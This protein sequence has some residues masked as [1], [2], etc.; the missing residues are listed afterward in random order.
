MTRTSSP[1]WV[2]AASKL[3]QPGLIARLVRSS[4]RAGW[5]RGVVEG[6]PAWTVAGGLA[7]LAYMAGRAWTKETD[8]IF[9]EQL[10]PGQVIR[11]AHDAAPLP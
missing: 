9:S 7:L 2:D 6:S 8:V 5:Q 4:M 11:I 1:D 3:V 10:L